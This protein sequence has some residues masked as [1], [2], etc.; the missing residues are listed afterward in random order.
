MPTEI[1]HAVHLV[2]L[3]AVICWTQTLG[4]PK[5]P[6]HGSGSDRGNPKRPRVATCCPN[7]VKH[8]ETDANVGADLPH[9]VIPS[10]ACPR[11]ICRV[12]IVSVEN[13][14][15]RAV[16][17]RRDCKQ[18]FYGQEHRASF[19]AACVAFPAHTNL[20]DCVDGLLAELFEPHAGTSTVRGLG[21]R[22]L[23]SATH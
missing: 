20:S 7:Q 12:R 10:V 23:T 15:D 22:E 9:N 16:A 3:P 5:A 19:S 14:R 21:Q 8:Q 13:S 11:R 17:E 6:G 1:R 2:D 18:N 4:G